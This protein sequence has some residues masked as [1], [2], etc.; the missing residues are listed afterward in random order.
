MYS[1]EEMARGCGLGLPRLYSQCRPQRHPFRC[2]SP[3]SY[4]SLVRRSRKFSQCKIDPGSPWECRFGPA[5]EFCRVLAFLHG[6]A[7][8]CMAFDSEGL[9]ATVCCGRPRPTTLG[10][11][12][13]NKSQSAIPASLRY[14]G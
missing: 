7:H 13:G 2:Q 5:P 8:P 14:F 1:R 6:A 10:H 3:D 9:G 11:A 12:D 4:S